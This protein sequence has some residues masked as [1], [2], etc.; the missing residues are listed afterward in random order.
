MK[1]LKSFKKYSE[2]LEFTIDIFNVD[3][4][5][6][7]NLFYENILKSV[8]SEEVDFYDT[9]K[10]QKDEKI[11]RSDLESINK[12][13][14]FIYSLSSIGLKNSALQSTDDFETFVVSPCRFVMIYRIEASDI[15]NPEYILFQSWDKSMSKWVDLKLY[16]VNGEIKNFYDKLSSKVIEIIDG[17]N[18]YIYQ[19]TNRN[20]WI[21]QNIESMNDKF[22]KYFRKDDFEKFINDN[23]FKFDIK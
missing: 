6:S 10:I 7:M 22:K 2:S 3:L 11:S 4:N 16:K 21:L 12:S 8:G 15:E 1:Y 9:F 18:N 13:H 5:E 17:E 19:S 23:K 20:E 14:E